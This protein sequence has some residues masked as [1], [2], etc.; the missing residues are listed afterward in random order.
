VVELLKGL[1]WIYP[2]LISAADCLTRGDKDLFPLM[3]T[4]LSLLITTCFSLLASTKQTLSFVIDAFSMFVI[5]T[6]LIT[7]N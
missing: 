3:F 6:F 4:L 1:S 7:W 5:S 2:R